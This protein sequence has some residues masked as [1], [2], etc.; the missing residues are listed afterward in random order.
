M[1]AYTVSEGKWKSVTLPEPSPGPGEVLL[2]VRATSLNYRDLIIAQGR[3]PGISTKDLI[4]LSDGAGEVLAVGPGVT[5]FKPGDRAAANFFQTWEA[6]AKKPED[7][8]SALGGGIDGM[9]AE[10]VVLRAGGLVKLPAH[11]SYEEAATLPCAG[12]TAWN[13]LME[14][15]APPKPGSVVLTLGTG[16]VSIFALQFAKAAGCA[17]IGTTSSEAK[18]ERL[19]GMGLDAGVNYKKDVEWQDAVKK[20]NGGLGVDQVIE[21]GGATLPRSLQ[22]VRMG[23]VISLIGGLA[24]FDAPIGLAAIS[25]SG[26]RLQPI[27]V[28]SVAMFEAMNRAIE[29]TKLKPIVDE[30]FPFDRANE[31]LAKLESGKHFGKIVI[32]L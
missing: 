6:G 21:V 7:N 2:G 17:V 27:S 10:K 22:C 18:L 32:H 25:R 29:S 31:A 30:V 8:A 16:G 20:A 15:P 1:R 14:S 28:G 26:A 12:L 11:L 24:G 3:H 4:P 13:A 23:G 9:L 19:M 5:R